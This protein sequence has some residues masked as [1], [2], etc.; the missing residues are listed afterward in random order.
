MTISATTA[1]KALFE[2]LSDKEIYYTFKSVVE[3]DCYISEFLDKGILELFLELMVA[4]KIIWIT[5][6]ERILLTPKGENLLQEI[7]LIVEVSQKNSKIK[8]NKKIWKHKP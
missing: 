6:D 5:S 4:T 1:F 7:S 3:D 8:K 2:A